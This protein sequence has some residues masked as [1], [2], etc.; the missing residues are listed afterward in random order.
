MCIRDSSKV[1]DTESAAAILEEMKNTEFQG[2]GPF[3]Y[4]KMIESVINSENP[5]YEE[6]YNLLSVTDARVEEK[7]DG[8]FTPINPRSTT[9]HY[10][11]VLQHLVRA[12]HLGNLSRLS[13]CTITDGWYN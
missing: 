8:V 3:T 1:G 12:R 5:D 10:N 9:K 11:T 13:F 7:R 2:P 4:L 6:M